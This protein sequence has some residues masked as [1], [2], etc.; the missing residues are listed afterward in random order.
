M[1]NCGG[2]PYEI[3]GDTEVKLRPRF[4]GLLEVTLKYRVRQGGEIIWIFQ[5]LLRV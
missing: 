2:A 5:D 3:L 4:D 1:Y